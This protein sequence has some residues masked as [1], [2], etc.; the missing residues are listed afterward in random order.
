MLFAGLTW[1]KIGR[2]LEELR[3]IMRMDSAANASIVVEAAVKST[4]VPMATFS[5]RGKNGHL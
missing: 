3:E 2:K 5:S 4:D 1:L